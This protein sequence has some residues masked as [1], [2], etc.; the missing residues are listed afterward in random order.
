M[1]LKNENSDL[2]YYSHYEQDLTAKRAPFDFEKS[3]A[4]IKYINRYYSLII[5]K[6]AA[7]KKQ[8]IINQ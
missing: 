7:N 4:I 1:P 3:S 6:K 2:F 8:E 5:I